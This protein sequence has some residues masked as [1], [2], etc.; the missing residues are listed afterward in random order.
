[1]YTGIKLLQAKEN[2]NRY[3]TIQCKP[4]VE[5]RRGHRLADRVLHHIIRN[6]DRNNITRL[7]KRALA[8]YPFLQPWRD[9]FYIR[10]AT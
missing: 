1:M 9:P 3:K 5:F 2:Y 10:N 7:L 8:R 4:Y 6:A